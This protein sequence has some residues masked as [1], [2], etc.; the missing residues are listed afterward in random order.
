MFRVIKFSK[1]V[2]RYI[3]SLTCVRDD[4]KPI[5]LESRRVFLSAVYLG[6]VPKP[7]NQYKGFFEVEIGEL[8]TR[9][10]QS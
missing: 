9:F 3:I 8:L 1:L 10:G 6:L 4:E 2:P 7:F 5:L